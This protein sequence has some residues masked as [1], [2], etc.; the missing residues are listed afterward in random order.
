MPKF[1]W[2]LE[3]G[4]LVNLASPEITRLWGERFTWTQDFGGF[5]P[6][7]LLRGVW[8]SRP[9][10]KN[11]KWREATPLMARE[12]LAKGGPKS[13]PP[14]QGPHWP[15]DLPLSPTPKHSTSSESSHYATRPLTPGLLEDILDSNNTTDQW[16]RIEDPPRRGYPG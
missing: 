10:W 8:Q 4:L 16:E 12:E 14:L 6:W 15:K 5:N 7:P 13:C 9:S 2:R 3:A 1:L 11:M